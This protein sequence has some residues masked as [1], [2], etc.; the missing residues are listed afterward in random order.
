MVIGPLRFD[1]AEYVKHNYRG[2]P[3]ADWVATA[4]ALSWALLESSWSCP[5]PDHLLNP[6]DTNAGYGDVFRGVLDE[7]KFRIGSRRAD[8]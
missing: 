6:W 8:Y 1:R 7:M 2:T 5:F 3:S 4:G